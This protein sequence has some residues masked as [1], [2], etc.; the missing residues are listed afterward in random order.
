MKYREIV[1]T[2]YLT[3]F[4]QS[5]WE[6]E[7]SD[8]DF[9]HTIIPDGYF[10]LIAEFQNG[11]LIL[12]KLTGVWTKPVNVSIP[13]ST[14]IFA[15]RFKLLAAEYLFQHEIRSILNTTQNLALNYWNID[16][17]QSDDFEK[18]STDISNRLDNCIKHLKEIDKRK[19]KLFEIVYSKHLPSVNE[20]ACEAFWNSRQINRYFNSRFGFSLKAFLNIV[21]CNASYKNIAKG[22]LFPDDNFFD[23]SHFI[24]EIR[25]HT[26]STPGELSKNQNVRFLQLT[27]KS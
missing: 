23:Q 25:K 9:E 6:Y 19:L 18:F 12:V 10:D 8:K 22:N 14:K 26:G 7:T 4:I 15:V 17:Y 1:P 11:T 16:Q 2:G 13:K 27:I 20:L 21:R 3:N 5:F 24:K